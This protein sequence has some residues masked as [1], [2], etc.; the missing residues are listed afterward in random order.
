MPWEKKIAI[1]FADLRGFTM[2]SEALPP[3]DVIYVLNRY[4]YCI[5]KVIAKHGGMINNYMGDGLMALFG[6]DDSVQAAERSVRAALEMVSAME[7]FNLYLESMY[8]QQLKIGIGI[9]YGEVVIGSVGASANSQQMT[10]I[11]DAVNLASRIEA[12]N[13]TL[14]TMLLVSEAVY[15]KVQNQVS[16]SQH[17]AVEIPGKTGQYN[18]YAVVGMSEAAVTVEPLVRSRQSGWMRWMVRGDRLWQWLW[19][20]LNHSLF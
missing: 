1:L 4:F 2:F 20:R 12:A 5:G 7:A 10:A 11:G 19:Q 6:C 18:L 15:S 13:K 17:C 16:V 9:H 8:Q 14:G 3:Y